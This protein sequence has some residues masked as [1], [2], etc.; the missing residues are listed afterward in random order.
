MSSA[1]APTDGPAPPEP[2]IM[3]AAINQ[4]NYECMLFT[5]ERAALIDV[6]R[7]LD[8]FVSTKKM[9]LE[10]LRQLVQDHEGDDKAWFV[11]SADMATKED[12]AEEDEEEDEDA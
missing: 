7:T 5:T 9:S 1:P 12:E 6:V 8:D 10:D 11:T 3:Y 2:S 4:E